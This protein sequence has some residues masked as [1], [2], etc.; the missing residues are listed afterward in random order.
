ME[1]LYKLAQEYGL[2]D[3]TDTGNEN[4]KVLAPRLN[5]LEGKV[6]GFLDNKKGNGLLLMTR[7][8][9]VLKEKYGIKEAVFTSKKIFSRTAEEEVIQRLATECDAVISAIGD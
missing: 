6:V 1:A 4:V 9:D 8:S 2:L 5:T 3:P 7:I